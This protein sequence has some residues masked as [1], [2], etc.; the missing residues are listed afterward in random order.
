MNSY[1]WRLSSLFM[2][3]IL[4]G[5]E[6]LI[7][8]DI[9][10]ADPQYVIVG[11]IN[12]RNRRHEVRIQRTVSLQS[13][14]IADPVSG[15]IVQVSDGK[16]QTHH[17]MEEESGLYRSDIFRGQ[18]GETYTLTVDIEGTKFTAQSS[19]PA[20]VPVDSVGTSMSS[21]M[22][23]ENKFVTFKFYDP[24][25][26][27]NFYRYLLNVNAEGAKFVSVFEDKYNDGKYVTHELINLD[28]KLQSN[29]YIR[30]QRQFIDQANFQYWQ[31]VA[32]ANPTAATPANPPSNISNGALGYFS[33]YS[34]I[35]YD[36]YIR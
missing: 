26:V 7:T 11:E 33:A 12:N 16:G 27:R 17:F 34:Y 32:S 15:A 10:D 8:L 2:I 25:A 1:L 4:V 31:N 36:I 23:E 5:C 18:V 6:D 20:P 13:T 35:E 24:P 21:F 19:L 30:V 22:G 3:L 29:D 14:Q 9:Q 28:I